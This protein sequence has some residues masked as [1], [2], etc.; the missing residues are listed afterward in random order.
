MNIS[1]FLLMMYI[2]M[3]FA[4]MKKF[5]KIINRD[6]YVLSNEYSY[7]G[8]MVL[9][10]G[11]VWTRDHRKAKRFSSMKEAEREIQE[12]PY[13]KGTQFLVCSNNENWKKAYKEWQRK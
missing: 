12:M 9:G 13:P 6:G 5:Y 7:A 10:Y 1:L 2:F 3:E 4:N 11:G 8:A